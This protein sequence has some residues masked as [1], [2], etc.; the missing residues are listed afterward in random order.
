MVTILYRVAG[1]A[2]IA[3]T[4][5]FSQTPYCS[6]GESPYVT[7]AP[8]P[9]DSA[10]RKTIGEVDAI[11]Y[12]EFTTLERIDPEE[13]EFVRAN[14]VNVRRD[15]S[16]C[17]SYPNRRYLL[18]CARHIEQGCQVVYQTEKQVDCGGSQE[19]AGQERQ[20]DSRKPQ[21]PASRWSRSAEHRSP[22]EILAAASN[23]AVLWAQVVTDPIA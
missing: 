22:V 7:V 9:A 6:A 10:E 11:V 19:M 3:A 21:R 8:L 15:A 14:G 12:S 16:N 2:G 5:L 13:A 17:D 18:S 4:I 23:G 1:L 20:W